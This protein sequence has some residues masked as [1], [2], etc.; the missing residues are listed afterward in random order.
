MI[1]NYAQKLLIFCVIISFL[2]IEIYLPE[3]VTQN[4]NNVFSKQTENN[5]TTL[6]LNFNNKIYITFLF[7][8]LVFCVFLLSTE[9]EKLFRLNT[10][11]AKHHKDSM[12]IRV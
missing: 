8:T 4:A 2:E 9:K 6:Q 3:G 7:K 5:M 11:T 10:E 12:S 1:Y